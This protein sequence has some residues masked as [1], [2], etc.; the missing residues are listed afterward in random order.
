MRVLAVGSMY[1]PH[2]MGGYELIW[3]SSVRHLRAAGH[4]VRV[5]ASD[6]AAPVPPAEPED[7]DVHRELR[8]YW[9]DHGFPRFSWRERIALERHNAEVFDRHVAEFAPD[10]VSW[11]AM[12]GMSL[13]LIERARR[14]GLP[15]VGFV[16][17]DWMLYG[18][19]ADRWLWPFTTRPRLAAIAERRTGLP[20]AYRPGEAARWVFVSEATRR[21]A[22]DQGF[23]LPDTAIEHAGIA[24]VFG[25]PSPPHDWSWR[26]LY[27]GRIEPRKGVD[28]AIKALRR[29]PDEARL[30]IAGDGDPGHLEE[31]RALARRR[32]AADRVRFLG[33]RTA[34]ELA[35]DYA[36]ADAA[37][38]PSRWDEPWG[39]VP[40]EAMARGRPVVTTVRG[41]GAEY[42]RD[43]E[44]CLA[45]DGDDAPG[46]AAA[47]ERLARDPAL[48]ATLREGGLATAARFT[49]ERYDRAVESELL[50][51][52]QRR[53]V[54]SGR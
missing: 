45:F 40:I 9:R 33:Q 26:L 1:P 48:R 3:Q 42:L 51:A 27:V 24:P 20:A 17:D 16:I 50:A 49:A 22:L 11:W 39:L 30:D 53:G 54:A 32:G 41:G 25:E 44:N 8:W 18:R 43:G 2:H 14:A 5:L 52:S 13:S 23:P 47:V 21:R 35:S 7:P 38:F 36:E 6:Y 46:L 31:L 37:V 15:A 34:Q 4:E 10:V 29:L 28:T 12:G 19:Q